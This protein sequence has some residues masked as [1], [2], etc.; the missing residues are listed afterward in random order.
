MSN[1]YE[2][3]YTSTLAPDAPVTAVAAIVATARLKNPQYD[4]T[5][6]LVFDGQHFCQ[7]LEGPRSAVL[8]RMERIREDA[9]HVDVDVVHHGVL[10]QRRFRRFTMGYATSEGEDYLQQIRGL[11]PK[12]ALERFLAM[13]PTLD[14]DS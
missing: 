1:L 5:G 12:P 6:L 7:Q 3:L 14:L 11:E 13:L 10:T 2:V 9:R 4:L 8:A